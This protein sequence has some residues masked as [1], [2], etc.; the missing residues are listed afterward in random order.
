VRLDRA[1]ADPDWRNLFSDA[2]VQHVVSSCLDH[3][4]LLI[5][6]HKDNWEKR[7]PRVFRYEVMWER[8]DSLS[9]EIKKEWCKLSDR[10]SLANFVHVLENMQSALRRWSKQ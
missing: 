1:V 5:E 4:P 10:G 3:Y 6:L 7:G 9:D 2:K 8:M